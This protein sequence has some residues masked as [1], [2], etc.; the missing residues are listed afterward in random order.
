TTTG[1]ARRG[2]H[3]WV[4]ERAGRPCRRCG[5]RI[6]TATQT[7]PEQPRYGR[8]CYWCPT[9]QHGPAPG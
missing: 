7:E 1:D 3:H 6:R 4:F 2:R 9:C 5:T 8:L